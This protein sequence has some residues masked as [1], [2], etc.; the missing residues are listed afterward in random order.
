MTYAE[1]MIHALENQELDKAEDFFNLS[2]KKDTAQDQVQLAEILLSKGFIQQAKTLYENKITHKEFS[3][4][5]SIGLAE[6]YIEEGNDAEAFEELM[7]IPE[8][9]PLYIQSLLVQADLYQTQGL[10]EV[11]EQKLR[12]AEQQYPDEPVIQFALGELLFEMGRYRLALVEYEKLVQE[13]YDEY[14]GTNLHFRMAE[15]NSLVGNWEKAIDM[16]KEILEEGEHVDIYFQLALIYIQ[17]EE[18]ESAI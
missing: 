8:E 14:A 4:E 10:Y 5:S 11:S 13:G 15:C 3:G 2:L 12:E 6:I 1:K 17:I 16:Y 9:S 7:K 18:Y